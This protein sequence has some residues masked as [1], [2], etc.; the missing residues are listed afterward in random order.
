M[1]PMAEYFGNAA[2]PALLDRWPKPEL[3]SHGALLSALC[4][5]FTEPTIE[6]EIIKELLGHIAALTEENQKLKL[7]GG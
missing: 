7:S 5:T 4:W 2:T 1:S 6:D 3:L